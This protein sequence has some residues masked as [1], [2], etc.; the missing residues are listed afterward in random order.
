M[1][2]SILAKLELP[3]SLI[4]FLLSAITF[5]YYLRY[6]EISMLRD[7]SIF[8]FLVGTIEFSSYLENVGAIPMG[9]HMLSF[10]ALIPFLAYVIYRL[11][12]TREKL[13]NL[14]VAMSKDLTAQEREGL[15]QVVRQVAGGEGLPTLRVRDVMQGDVLTAT[16]GMSINEALSAMEERGLSCIVVVEGEVPVGIVTMRDIIR[17]GILRGISLERPLR[18]VMSSPLITVEGGMGVLEA[19]E[20]MVGKDIRKLPVVEGGKLRGLISLTDISR[21]EPKYIAELSRTLK[22]IEGILGGL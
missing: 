21:I 8:V 12:T 6:R 18:E 10:A 2:I 11:A 1:D 17:K 5:R 3:I 7:F 16:P 19:G 13:N 14:L 4:I 22:K 9:F 20:L 15:V